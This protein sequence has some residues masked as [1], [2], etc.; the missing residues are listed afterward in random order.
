MHEGHVRGPT[1]A[2]RRLRQSP[3]SRHGKY[4]GHPRFQRGAH[5]C[6]SSMVWSTFTNLLAPV[7]GQDGNGHAVAVAAL[8][9]LLAR[10]ELLKSLIGQQRI[11]RSVRRH[12]PSRTIMVQDPTE[13]EPR[14][15]ALPLSTSRHRVPAEP[16]AWP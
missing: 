6:T 1:R 2:V 14:K 15:R 16:Q 8:A 5:Q 3:R 10:L 7:D 4:C 11:L 9:K 13:T 12:I